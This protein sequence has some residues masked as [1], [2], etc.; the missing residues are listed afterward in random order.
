M[1]V[2]SFLRVGKIEGQLQ[3]T[4]QAQ[5]KQAIALVHFC[6][7]TEHTRMYLCTCIYGHADKNQKEFRGRRGQHQKN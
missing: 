1:N 2:S 7:S 6:S 5:D 4:S 3:Q